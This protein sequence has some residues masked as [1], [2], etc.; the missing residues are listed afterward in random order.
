MDRPATSRSERPTAVRAARVAALHLL[1]PAPAGKRGESTAAASTG[2]T[3]SGVPAAPSEKRR[4]L[5]QTMGST[6]EVGT[7]EGFEAPGANR[8]RSRRQTVLGNVGKG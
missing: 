3:L 2:R 1:L 7:H 6:S 4:N 8:H 5:A